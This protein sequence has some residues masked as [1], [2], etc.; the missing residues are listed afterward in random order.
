MD[1][2]KHL[3]WLIMT[4]W[5]QSFTHMVSVMTTLRSSLF[6]WWYRSKINYKFSSWKEL[7]PWNTASRYFF[8]ISNYHDNLLQLYLL[9]WM[10]IQRFIFVITVK[11]STLIIGSAFHVFT[12]KFRRWTNRFFQVALCFLLL[13]LTVDSYFVLFMRL[14]FSA[15]ECAHLMGKILLD[16]GSSKIGMFTNIVPITLQLAL[17]GF[18]PIGNLFIIKDAG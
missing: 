6:A 15:Q 18:F 16:V 5:L 2:P 14:C 17:I 12:D 1:F 9:T 3:K 7:S 13:I 10:R 11:A 8:L 4:I